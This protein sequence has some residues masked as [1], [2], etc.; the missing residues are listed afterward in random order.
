MSKYEQTPQQD[1]TDFLTTVKGIIAIFA[2][3][4]VVVVIVMLFASNM[5]VSSSELQQ[6]TK[7]GHLTE[8]QYVEA[9]DST[10]EEVVTTTAASDDDEDEDEDEDSSEEQTDTSNLPEGLDTSV[11]GTYVVSSAVYLRSESNSSSSTIMTLPSG[12]SV[13]VYGS[14]NYGWYY[15][16]YEGT[17]GYAYSS[18]LSAQ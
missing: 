13:T 3:I 11:A 6:S 9:S 4:L 8:T 5:F 7:T 14:E 10:T 12:A 1:D 16:S 17:Y 18:Y 2:T 15:L